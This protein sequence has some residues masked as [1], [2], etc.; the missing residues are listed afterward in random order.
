LH[1]ELVRG[2]AND[3]ASPGAVVVHLA[4]AA[5][6]LLAVVRPVWLEDAALV[7]EQG[8]RREVADICV[9]LLQGRRV[10]VLPLRAWCSRLQLVHLGPHDLEQA[11]PGDEKRKQQYGEHDD[12]RNAGGAS[13]RY[14]EG[15]L[16]LGRR[17][18]KILDAY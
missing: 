11:H 2:L 15:L 10:Y 16:H 13:R 4:H 1:K 9:A 12:E 8:I 17:A 6:Q 7:A 5:A 3:A 18:R 14:V